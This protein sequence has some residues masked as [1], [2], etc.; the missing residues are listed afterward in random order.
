MYTKLGRRRIDPPEQMHR[1]LLKLLSIKTELVSVKSP[2][3]RD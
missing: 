2:E 3:V 1:D